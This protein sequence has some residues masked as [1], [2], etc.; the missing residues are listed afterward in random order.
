M[1]NMEEE[2]EEKRVNHLMEIMKSNS[3]T[4]REKEQA[5][6][7]YNQLR[8]MVSGYKCPVGYHWVSEF[9]RRVNGGIVHGLNYAETVKGHCAKNPKRKY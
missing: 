9:T 6:E 4:Y 8:H 7:E 5:N 2:E 3:S 1:S